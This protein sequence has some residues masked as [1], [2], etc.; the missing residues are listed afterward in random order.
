MRTIMILAFVLI[1]MIGH[2][3]VEVKLDSIKVGD[4]IVCKKKCEAIFD[5]YNEGYVFPKGY[6]CIVTEVLASD[7]GKILMIDVIDNSG[8][9]TRIGIDEFKAYEKR[10]KV[11]R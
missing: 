1:G 5:V 4:E 7:E 11:C 10:I 6:T 8:E 2:A 3:Q 9:V